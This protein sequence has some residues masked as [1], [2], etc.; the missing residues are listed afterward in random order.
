MSIQSNL[1]DVE[2][3]RISQ[4]ISFTRGIIQVLFC[5]YACN[6]LHYHNFRNILQMKLLSPNSEV[7][8][9]S[10]KFFLYELPLKDFAKWKLMVSIQYLSAIQYMN[11]KFLSCSFFFF[12]CEHFTL[13]K[14]PLHNTV[15]I[16]VTML[17]L[18]SSLYSFY[19]WK[20]VTPF[21]K[22]LSTPQLPPSS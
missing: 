12:W 9:N 15:L 4:A 6:C 18:R 5:L 20:F 3:N 22:P 13:S 1:F 14:F 10:N 2:P 11:S 17:Y 21:H 8:P 16:I 7:F 19:S